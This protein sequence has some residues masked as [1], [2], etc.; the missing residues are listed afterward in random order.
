MY[1]FLYSEY[2]ITSIKGVN[3]KTVMR[4]LLP[5]ESEKGIASSVLVEKELLIRFEKE[6]N[7][8]KGGKMIEL[9][10]VM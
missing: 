1:G 2:S 7:S 8:K 4:I 6:Y 10:F 9:L 5:E 3:G